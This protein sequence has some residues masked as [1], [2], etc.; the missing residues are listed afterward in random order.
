MYIRACSEDTSESE[1]G[2]VSGG[3]RFGGWAVL[4]EVERDDVTFGT[5]LYQPLRRDSVT[6]P[7]FLPS[8]H[9]PPSSLHH[10]QLNTTVLRVNPIRGTSLSPTSEI[11]LTYLC[12]LH[13]PPCHLEVR[14]YA[15]LISLMPDCCL[16]GS[17]STR[18]DGSLHVF[19][20]SIHFL[21]SLVPPTCAHVVLNMRIQYFF[22]ISLP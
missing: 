7:L 12:S 21:S 9:H 10:A 17:T 3:V 6:P 18:H 19:F 14:Q 11:S 16:T 8:H 20:F 13:R 15:N 1:T 5:A 22:S 2:A 4:G